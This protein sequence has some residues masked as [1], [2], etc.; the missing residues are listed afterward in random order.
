M[1]FGPAEPVRMSAGGP[2]SAP[3]VS[4]SCPGGD[5]LPPIP[6]ALSALPGLMGEVQEWITSTMYKPHWGVAGLVTLA[7][8]D[9]MAMTH[10]RIASRSGLAMGEFFMVLAP[11]AF[12]KESLRTPF[13]KLAEHAM[14]ERLTLPD[15]HFSAPSSMQGLQEMLMGSRAMAMLP[16]EFGDWI[17]KGDKEHHREQAMAHLMQVYGNPFGTVDVPRAISRKLTPVK[18]P[19]MVLFGTSTGARFSEVI[20]GSIADRGF[21]NRFVML[22]VG[23]DPLEIGN[24]SDDPL[25]YE[26]PQALATLAKR[27]CSGGQT[28]TFDEDATEY[29]RAHLRAVLDPLADSD[30]RLAGRLNEQA[31]RIAAAFAMNEGRCVIDVR[32]MAAA[33]EIREGLYQRTAAFFASEASLTGDNPTMRALEQV[34]NVLKRNGSMSR[35]RLRDN[36]RQFRR[37]SVREQSDVLRALVVEGVVQDIAGRL[38]WTEGN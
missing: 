29:K 7:L 1:G 36:A 4:D 12:G 16:D 20:N 5:L 35:S 3:D 19:R 6:D 21:L 38:Y 31:A 9:Y 25:A 30:N 10:T 18:E 37:L 8:I 2:E 33:Y 28:I 15:L 34:R 13:R 22:P 26:I 27:I 11:S 32:D 23:D 17:A 14:R 24:E